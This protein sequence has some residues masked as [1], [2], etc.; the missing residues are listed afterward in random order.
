MALVKNITALAVLGTLASATG[1]SAASSPLGV[2]IDHTERGAVEISQCGTQLCG[3][4]VW[5]KSAEDGKNC[6]TEILG[7]VVSEGS[8]TWGG[9]WIYSP[10]RKKK[11]NV[12]ITPLNNGNL[13]VVGY[14]GIR[15]L[16]KTMIWTPAPADLQRCDGV[17][18]G[19]QAAPAAAPAP[20]ATGSVEPA[21]A[22]VADGGTAPVAPDQAAP[23][24]AAAAPAP[25]PATTDTTATAPST[26]ETAVAEAPS[27]SFDTEQF[28]VKRDGENIEVG[29][30][31]KRKNGKCNV[32]FGS[33][34]MNFDCDGKDK[35]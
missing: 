5:I 17:Q 11:Y 28:G 26:N 1:A 16:S 9:G 14:K 32:S 25:A 35:D 3:K 30:I 10:E 29:D 15:F 13:Q 23:A 18:Q 19:A 24:Q 31:F 20:V 12:E 7:E 21:P 27:E 2:W 22:P 33:F 34:N 8:N 4:V 6:G